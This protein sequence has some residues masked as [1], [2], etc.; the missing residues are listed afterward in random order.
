MS[1]T[2]CNVPA[3]CQGFQPLSLK[4]VGTIMILILKN[5]EIL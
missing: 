2:V 1:F 4:E 3:S 5:L